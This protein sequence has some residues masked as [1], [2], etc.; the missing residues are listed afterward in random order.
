MTTSRNTWQKQAVRDALQNTPG[1]VS[2]Q[3]LHR[4]LVDAGH[5]LSLATVYRSL[6]TLAESGDADTLLSPAGEALY[7]ACSSAS[8]HHHLVCRACGV[9]VEV[10]ANAVETWAHAV[11]AQHG[12]RDAAHNVDV[13]GTCAN[14]SA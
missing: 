2:A 8:H 7:R 9:T 14:C 12:F 5:E 13:F 4:R 1:F 6:S 3:A 11:A 10:E